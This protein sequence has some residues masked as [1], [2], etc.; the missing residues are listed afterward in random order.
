MV[1]R[2]G[3]I[4]LI[5][6][7]GALWS[8]AALLGMDELPQGEG[9]AEAGSDAPP[10][11]ARGDDGGDRDARAGDG[12]AN[13]GGE[14]ASPFEPTQI[15]GGVLWYR[16]DKGVSVDGGKVTSWQNSFSVDSGTAL[17]PQRQPDLV[18][19][20]SWAQKPVVRF[21][22]PNTALTSGEA[23]STD[24][25]AS[26]GLPP[27]TFY[28]AFISGP[29]VQPPVTGYYVFDGIGAA[30]EMYRLVVDSAD[31]SLRFQSVVIGTGDAV[32]SLKQDVSA[33]RLAVCAV[34]NGAQSALYVSSLTAG[35]TGP[36][37]N[38][39]LAGLTVGASYA[40]NA[41]LQGSVA[42]ILVYSGAHGATERRDVMTYLSQ[43]YQIPLQ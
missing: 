26:G 34:A 3:V 18:G 31:G 38:L 15:Q 6:A 14:A 43:R 35:A 13:D 16:A 32:L 2:V 37:Q 19:D 29:A 12:D 24:P 11:Q 8:C 36:L 5:G 25:F 21:V 27:L 1:E 28:A 7:L 17:R 30:T 9:G 4:F 39:R 23:M 20:P 10:D 41:N 40:G 22:S 42:E 33:K